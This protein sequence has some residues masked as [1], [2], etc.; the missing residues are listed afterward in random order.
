MTAETTMQR[1]SD[2]LTRMPYEPY[3]GVGEIPSTLIPFR[4]KLR[5]ELAPQSLADRL[6]AEGIEAIALRLFE[7]GYNLGYSVGSESAF[8]DARDWARMIRTERRTEAQTFAAM[9]CLEKVLARAIEPPRR[10]DDGDD[11]P[12]AE[13]WWATVASSSDERAIPTLQPS[14]PAGDTIRPGT[15]VERARQFAE[16]HAD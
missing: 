5:A 14:P 10:A 12:L 7:E 16:A 11:R 13:P 3:P 15:F 2:R 6:L 8:S 4:D 1:E 9:S